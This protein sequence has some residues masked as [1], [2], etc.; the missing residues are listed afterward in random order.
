MNARFQSQVEAAAASFG[1]PALSAGYTVAGRSVRAAVGCDPDAVFRVASITKPFTALLALELLDLEEPRKSGPTTSA[2]ATCSR[3]RA[4][5]TARCGDLARFG[6]GDD[7]LAAAVSEL[8]GVRRYFGVEQVWSYA[9]TG[10][11]LA[12]HLAAERAGTSVRGCA[13]RSRH[14]PRRAR[15]DLLR[16][17]GARRHRLSCHVGPVPA[18]PPPLG[19]ARVD[20]LRPAAL[21]CSGSWHVRTP[22]SCG[23]VTRS[24]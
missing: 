19:R 5:T 2:S 16:R 18:G 4:V 7:A 10:Y 11:W 21:R 13:A 1:V 14:P 3:T 9:N 23:C 15:V 20:R 12:G 24:P 6:A 8:P 22:R 17:A